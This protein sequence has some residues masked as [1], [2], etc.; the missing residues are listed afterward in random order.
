VTIPQHVSEELGIQPH[1]EVEFVKGKDGNYRLKVKRKQH[2]RSRFRGLRGLATVRM[3][4]DEIMALTRRW[5]MAELLVDSNVLLDVFE[6]D[7][8]WGDWSE[9]MLDQMSETRTLIIKPIIYSEVS[10]GFRGIEE[11]EDVIDEADFGWGKY[12]RNPFS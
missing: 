6:D 12:Q 2:G 5:A 8:T 4:T 9:S 7:A 10:I 1:S 3:T 11:L